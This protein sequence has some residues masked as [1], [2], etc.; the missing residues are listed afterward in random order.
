MSFQEMKE[1]VR[2]AFEELNNLAPV[3]GIS[4]PY[5]SDDC[6]SYRQCSSD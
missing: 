5:M 4:G 1:N 6:V 2:H 3:D